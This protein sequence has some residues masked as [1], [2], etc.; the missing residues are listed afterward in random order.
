MDMENI[1][2]KRIIG[3]VGV[4]ETPSSSSDPHKGIPQLQNL[5]IAFS[6]KPM[7]INMP[8]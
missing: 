8:T 7:V 6:V 1:I 2:P 3:L 4:L 5:Q